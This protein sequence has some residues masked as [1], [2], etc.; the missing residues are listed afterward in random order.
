MLPPSP[1]TPGDSSPPPRPPGPVLVG[2]GGAGRGGAGITSGATFRISVV[3]CV[4]Q[5]LRLVNKEGP[6]RL[7]PPHCVRK[8]H[9]PTALKE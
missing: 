2:W 5:E 8:A 6:A 4:G 1:L 9:T 3:E 7:P